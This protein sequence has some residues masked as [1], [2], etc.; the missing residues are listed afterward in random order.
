MTEVL[1]D[2]PVAASAVQ[3]RV[4]RRRSDPRSSI[5]LLTDRDVGCLFW[6]K[7][8]SM[9]GT[10]AFTMVGSIVV[11]SETGSGLAVGLVGTALYLPQLLLTT[12]VGSRADRGRLMP[13][14]LAGGACMT[15][16]SGVLAAWLLLLPVE[17]WSFAAAVMACSVI[18][19][20]GVVL[21]GSPMQVIVPR[22]VSRRELPAAMTI[23]FAPMTLARVAGPVAGAGLVA[24]LGVGTSL[25]VVTLCQAVAVAALLA[26]REPPRVAVPSGADLSMRAALRHVFA[27][28]QVMLMLVVATA[29]TCGSEPSLT[30]AAPLA[31]D[32]GTGETFIGALTSAFG[33]GG[34]FGLFVNRMLDRY[35][36]AAHG[37]VCSLAAMSSGLG[38][39]AV[40]PW[41]WP[42]L[43]GFALAGVGFSVAVAR[44]ATALM[45][46]VPAA[47]VG[48]VL[49]LWMLCFVG[50][51]PFASALTGLVTDLSSVRLAVAGMGA[52]TATLLGILL[53]RSILIAREMLRP[54]G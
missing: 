11:Y 15:L 48:R 32:L 39:A 33:V 9:V 21:S 18:V 40:S 42:A 7:L 35:G 52:I 23:N 45:V 41:A 30:L 44:T 20:T 27:D 2:S 49:S 14:M 46:R 6:A 43:L 51:R 10:W 31:H 22:L 26:V 1:V 24:S 53:I 12:I 28:R 25:V 37:I 13:L 29:V 3:P 4:G 19:G 34:L 50:V 8:A 36:W 17:G 5:Q 54:A 38:L 47:L 16:G